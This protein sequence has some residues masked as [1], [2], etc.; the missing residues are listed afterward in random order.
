VTVVEVSY[1][2]Q[3]LI[4][5]DLLPIGSTFRSLSLAEGQRAIHTSELSRR[6]TV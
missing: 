1:A 3:P 5:G 6:L 4:C 2:Y